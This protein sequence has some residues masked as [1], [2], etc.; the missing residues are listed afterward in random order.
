M[1]EI[2]S[3]LQARIQFKAE[4]IINLMKENERNSDNH[5]GWERSTVWRATPIIDYSIAHTAAAES[6]YPR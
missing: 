1:P 6:T 5:S 3:S 2:V 4:N